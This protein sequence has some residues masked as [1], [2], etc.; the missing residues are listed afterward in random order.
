M[1]FKEEDL[2]YDTELKALFKYL[3]PVNETDFTM[4]NKMMVFL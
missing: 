2:I 4:L 3:R 1:E